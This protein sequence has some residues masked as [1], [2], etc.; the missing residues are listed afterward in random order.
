MTLVTC[1]IRTL[2]PSRATSEARA[3]MR[4]LAAPPVCSWDGRVGSGGTGGVGIC[5]ALNLPGTCLGLAWDLIAAPEKRGYR[6]KCFEGTAA[7]RPEL[8]APTAE[9]CYAGLRELRLGTLERPDQWPRL[10]TQTDDP[11]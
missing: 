11:D 9:G 3:P 4:S 1:L 8:N 5:R 10:M 6:G 7:T 2:P